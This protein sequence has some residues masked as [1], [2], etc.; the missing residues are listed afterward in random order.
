MYIFHFTFLPGLIRGR[1]SDCFLS[2]S[3]PMLLRLWNRKVKVESFCHFLLITIWDGDK[4]VYFQNSLFQNVISGKVG[5]AILDYFFSELHLFF[6]NGPHKL[7]FV[8]SCVKCF[9]SLLSRIFLQ[10]RC[11]RFLKSHIWNIK[12]LIILTWMLS[13]LISSL[14]SSK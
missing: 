3:A 7:A 12:G 4:L 8:T 1:F 2:G 13:V 10:H 14:E 6:F 5:V 9:C 11:I